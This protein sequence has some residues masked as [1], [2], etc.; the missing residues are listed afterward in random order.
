MIHTV[1][2]NPA[3]DLT[4]RVPQW[5]FDDTTRA[6]SVLRA[7][8]GKGVNVSRVATR[9]GHETVA[10]GLVGGRTGDE[11]EDLLRDEGVR[12]WFSRHDAP[13]RS[14]VIVQDDTGRQLRISAP[15]PDVG[16]AEVEALL[17]ALFD[18]RAPDFLVASG[19]LLPGV[20]SDL[21]A[22]IAV[23]AA[24][25]GV[26]MIVDADRELAS[27][28]AAGVALTKPNAYELGRLVGR[29]V[30]DVT[31]AVTAA[32]EAVAMGA[33]VVVCSLGAHGAV[34][35]SDEGAWHA[36]PPRVKVDSALGAG[37][38]L[39]AGV[40]VAR[41]RGASP[42]EALQLGVACGTAT[43]MTP[44]TELC[45]RVDVEALLDRVVVET[46]TERSR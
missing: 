25:D 44:G 8:G 15:G 23:Q 7:P 33:R 29:D 10:M 2:V 32:R 35:V 4:Y 36:T 19:S 43:A 31:S 28:I 18:L 30:V 42:A 26:P 1:T 41:A 24:A 37:D 9:L 38:S 14:N 34:W 27:A 3:I 22:R 6:R 20:P 39:L 40:L 17:A 12:T 13:T 11:I 46:I 5:T 16:E 45:H 21:Y